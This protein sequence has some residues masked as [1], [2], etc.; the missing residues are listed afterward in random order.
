L[1]IFLLSYYHTKTYYLSFFKIFYYYNNYFT[2]FTMS[3]ITLSIALIALAIVGVSAN[4]SKFRFNA[5]VGSLN[6]D[7]NV[8]GINQGHL[9]A[10]TDAPRFLNSSDP[11]VAG[12]D[13]VGWVKMLSGTDLCQYVAA[14][15]WVTTPLSPASGFEFSFDVVIEDKPRGA[16]GLA[17]VLQPGDTKVANGGTGGYIGYLQLPTYF[18]IEF[19][20]F[21][22][23]D[24]DVH[25]NEVVV[26]ARN[27]SGTPVELHRFHI[28]DDQYFLES[29]ELRTMKVSYDGST[30]SASFGNF[31]FDVENVSQ[32]IA[33]ALRPDG[34]TTAG[35]TSGEAGKCEDIFVR[36]NHLATGCQGD[37]CDD[38]VSS[39]DGGCA[40][41]VSD[42]QTVTLSA[43][44]GS[45]ASQEF[46]GTCGCIEF[47]T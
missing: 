38:C 21:F 39:S 25:E 13:P 34:T 33:Y 12:T 14:N 11:Q 2:P 31:S 20:T 16:D 46:N 4:V 27:N 44:A 1:F 23:A 9:D 45:W 15:A 24:M 36:V 30:F 43:S 7:F 19:D 42:C 18:A 29:G 32:Y 3:R 41:L 37:S 10:S 35:L 5:Q 22:N 47:S 8:E 28:P 6:M 40:D 17:F 26:Q